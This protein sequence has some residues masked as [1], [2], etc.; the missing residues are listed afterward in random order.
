[1]NPCI[2]QHTTFQLKE[3]V[4]FRNSTRDTCVTLTKNTKSAQGP[5]NGQGPQIALSWKNQIV[6][7]GHDSEI[8]STEAIESNPK[9]ICLFCVTFT[10]TEQ[11]NTQI[12]RT[13]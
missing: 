13:P 3:F 11:Q 7:S 4:T 1:M 6:A 10:N 12:L 8:E 2:N 5:N 9:K